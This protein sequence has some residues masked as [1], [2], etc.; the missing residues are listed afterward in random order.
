[1][2]FLDD[3]GHS[4]CSGPSS[5][6][7]QEQLFLSTVAH[8]ALSEAADLPTAT[9]QG[10]Q[11]LSFRKHIFLE[12]GKSGS[13]SLAVGDLFL[14]CRRPPSHHILTW[15]RYLSE[16]GACPVLDGWFNKL[17]TSYIVGSHSKGRRR[18]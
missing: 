1:M 14:V 7:E 4:H 18:K 6:R 5:C 2:S 17:S 12:V 8:E 13:K 3:P 9:R 15:Q 10:W 11:V 16:D